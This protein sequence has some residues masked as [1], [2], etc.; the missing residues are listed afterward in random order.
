[1][2]NYDVV[3]SML[4]DNDGQDI[5]LAIKGTRRTDVREQVLVL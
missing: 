1:M 2:N 4:G 5:G 3:G